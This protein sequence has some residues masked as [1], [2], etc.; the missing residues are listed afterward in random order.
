[1]AMA[2]FTISLPA[3]LHARVVQ[4]AQ[5]QNRTASGQIRQWIIE[6]IRHADALPAW[7]PVRVPPSM[8]TPAEITAARDE[9]ARLVEERDRLLRLR[10][11]TPTGLLPH[12]DERFRFLRDE[13]RNREI[14]LGLIDHA[15]NGAPQ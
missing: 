4:F 5:R 12:Q 15:M 8:N 14:E 6:A 7:P 13:I 3:E 10:S 9:L 1:M 2:Q 11:K